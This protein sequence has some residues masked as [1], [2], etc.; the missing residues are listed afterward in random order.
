MHTAQLP[1][2]M[3]SGRMSR[4]TKIRSETAREIVV[5][6]R[7]IVETIGGGLVRPP[8]HAYGAV[9]DVD[10]VGPHVEEDEDLGGSGVSQFRLLEV[11]FVAASVQEAAPVPSAE[12][13]EV[14]VQGHAP[15]A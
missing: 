7:Q 15:D 1:M 13:P 8:A 11:K 12:G 2:S 9:A 5:T 4:K 10:A 3:L 6:A 14:E